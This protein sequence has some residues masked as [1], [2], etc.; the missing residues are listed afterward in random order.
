LN[1]LWAKL[2]NL[3]KN[4]LSELSFNTWIKTIIPL[5]VDHN[6]IILEVPTEFAKGILETRYNS[7]IVD[8]ILKITGENYNISY[9]VKNKN[10]FNR[11]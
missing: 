4:E 11:N 10:D 8:N 1:D 7:L 9:T 6:N 3:L 2:L 5:Q